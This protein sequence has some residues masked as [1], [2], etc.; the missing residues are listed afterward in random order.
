MAA[1][2]SYQQLQAELSEVMAWFEN[3][4]Q[5]LDVDEAIARYQ[6]GMEL[7]K[8]LEKQLKLAE[9][10]VTKVTTDTA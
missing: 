5:E 4:N 2:K 8:Q 10:K 7:V 9:N 6:K 1:A 3:P